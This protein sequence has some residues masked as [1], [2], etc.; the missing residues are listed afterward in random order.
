M[1]LL[2]PEVWQQ[3]IGHLCL[4]GSL[5][6]FLLGVIGLSWDALSPR[7]TDVGVLVVNPRISDR[8]LHQYHWLR[9]FAERTLEIG[10]S[11]TKLFRVAADKG[12]VHEFFRGLNLSLE[13]RGDQL[14]VST[15]VF[16]LHHHLIAKLENGEWQVIEGEAADYN[17][18][19]DTLEIKGTDDR[20]VLQVRLLP[21]RVQIQ[22][23]SWFANGSGTRLVMREPPNT[24][25]FLV[26]LFPWK[27]PD[28][29]HIEPL[30]LYPGK[31]HPGACAKAP[32]VAS[33]AADNAMFIGVCIYAALIFGLAVF[34]PI[35]HFASQPCPMKNEGLNPFEFGL[36]L[37][38]KIGSGDNSGEV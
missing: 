32:P 31:L 17:Y 15:A 10:Q 11:G 28:E 26:P 27:N 33:D 12:P 14:I 20:I 1:G 35:V 25:S 24:G 36:P 2:I 34:L 30:C 5:A 7:R 9:P 23:E 37:R 4:V 16:D 29:P 8:M 19:D 6:F 38:A 18:S 21:D 3:R 13:R 22:G